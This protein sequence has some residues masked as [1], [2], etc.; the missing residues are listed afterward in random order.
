MAK[1]KCRQCGEMVDR[2]NA[3]LHPD[4]D[5]FYY[6]SQSCLKKYINNHKIKPNKEV[7]TNVEK[8]GNTN[9]TETVN[10]KPINENTK[11]KKPF[12]QL[13]DYIQAHF[14]EQGY[15]KDLINWGLIGKQINW[16]STEYGYKYQGMLL[17]LEYYVDILGKQLNL[18]KG[19][20][21][22]IEKYYFTAMEYFLQTRKCYEL[23]EN[24]GEDKIKKMKSFSC[25]NDRSR[26]IIDM[27]SL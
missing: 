17:T 12:V 3:I 19:V 7:S 1:V 5:R 26:Y 22:P 25:K 13:T 14:V 24:F 10:K 15:D 4:K 11:E 6:C 23:S 8:T 16:L 21:F 20:V 2:D 18:D 27:N 9:K